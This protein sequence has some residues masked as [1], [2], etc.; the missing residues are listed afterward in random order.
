MREGSLCLMALSITSCRW[1][2]RAYCGVVQKS[3]RYTT[4]SAWTYELKFDLQ[5]RGWKGEKGKLTSP[6]NLIAGLDNDRCALPISHGVETRLLQNMSIDIISVGGK[7]K[8]HKLRVR[9]A[10][11]RWCA[12]AVGVGP[13]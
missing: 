5:D 10:Y 1:S 13:Y 11:G 4:S 12:S 7:C 9:D 3:S 6:R 8:V 2:R